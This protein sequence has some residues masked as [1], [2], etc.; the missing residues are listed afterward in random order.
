MAELGL[1][2]L[3]PRGT[4][5]YSSGKASSII[6]LIFTTRQLAGDLDLC[7]IYDCNHELDHE[8]LHAKFQAPLF[9]VAPVPRLLYKNAPWAKICDQIQA[10]TLKIC[11]TPNEIEE[12]A[13]Q[14]MAV[15][16]EAIDQCVPKAKSCLYAKR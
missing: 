1:Q 11:T 16:T 9:L 10:N 6:I 12:Y 8:A 2:S 13:S 3:L 4:I 14:I 7:E 15:V 5:I